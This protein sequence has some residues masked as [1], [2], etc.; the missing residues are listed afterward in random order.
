MTPE[1]PP[2]AP[3]DNIICLLAGAVATALLYFLFFP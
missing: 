2:D 3:G 1:P